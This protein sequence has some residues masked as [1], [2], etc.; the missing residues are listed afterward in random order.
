MNRNR[1]GFPRAQRFAKIVFVVSG[2]G[3]VAVATI[4]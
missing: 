2:G 4:R 1:D 3:F